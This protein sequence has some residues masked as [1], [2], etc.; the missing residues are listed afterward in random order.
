MGT[1]Q[2]H[3]NQTI[4]ERKSAAEKTGKN[5][6]REDGSWKPNELR[7]QALESPGSGARQSPGDG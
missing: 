6:A 1:I 4:E 5:L 3:V 2:P 7:G